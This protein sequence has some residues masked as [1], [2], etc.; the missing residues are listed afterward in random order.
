MEFATFEAIRQGD[1]RLELNEHLNWELKGTRIRA[2]HRLRSVL[3]VPITLVVAVSMLDPSRPTFIIHDG[4]AGRNNACRLDIRG[5]HYNRRTDRRRWVHES[6]LH[7]WREDCQDAHAV[8]PFPPWPPTWFQDHDTQ[9]TSEQIRELFE[10]FCR[11]FH[12]KLGSAYDWADPLALISQAQAL[13]T[14]DGDVIP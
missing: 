10:M 6:H 2:T 11:M 12:V 7:L 14:E 4:A 1:A 3:S 9:I 5:S 8:D 13:K